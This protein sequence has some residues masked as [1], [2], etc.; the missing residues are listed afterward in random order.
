MAAKRLRDE[1]DDGESDQPSND[2]RMRAV[3]SIS[4]VVREALA[5]RSF[6]TFAVA[7]EPLLR[8]VVNEEVERGIVQG[9]RTLQRSTSMRQIQAAAET[10]T[11]QLIFS[12]PLSLPIFTGSKI[13]DNEGNP[14]RVLLVDARSGSLSPVSSL[15][16]SVRVE[17]VVLDGDFPGKR[18]TWTSAE[19]ERNIVKERTG[20]R[21]LVTGDVFLTLRAG[22]CA[23]D[24][25][26]FTDNSSWIRSRHFRL[27]ARVASG[28][29][30][31]LKIKEAMTE[32][33]VVKDHRGELYKK[34][35][36][37]FLLDE[38]WRLEKIGKEGVFH[39]KLRAEGINTVQEFL[40]LW[41]VDHARLRNILGQGMSDRVWEG[42]ISHARTC[43]MGSKLYL[44]R[45]PQCVLLLNPICQVQGVVM[46]GQIYPPQNFQE[47][48]QD[49]LRQL[50]R[51]AYEHWHQLEEVDET[52]S[53]VPSQPQRKALPSTSTQPTSSSSIIYHTTNQGIPTSTYQNG[54]FDLEAL[55]GD[56][57]VE[58]GFFQCP[59]DASMHRSN[60]VYNASEL[61]S[62]DDED[63]NSAQGFFRG[64]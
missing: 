23:I 26:N 60:H 29:C 33:F 16:S 30:R 62:E 10:T 7:L 43:D 2:K 12:N 4:T 61:S 34:H 48:Q 24:D 19:F 40:K 49:F 42:T 47:P 20:K 51:E 32:P 45:T 41:V 25:L 18:E 28:S 50:A 6:Q 64:F 59:D 15:P 17:I 39:Q 14:L 27:G 55:Q 5:L 9:A 63:P 58:L 13:E 52:F 37:P 3:P 31:G 21:P 54:G 8:R 44:H 22:S 46:N 53:R 56:I 35:Y 57:E 11:L 36:P 38:V 1:A